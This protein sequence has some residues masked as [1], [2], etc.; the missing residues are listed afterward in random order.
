MNQKVDVKNELRLEAE[1]LNQMINMMTLF[2][3]KTV[4]EWLPDI[5]SQIGVSGEQLSIML[6]LNMAP[7][8]NLKNLA[9]NLM[10]APSNV[11]V[12]IQI[13]V[14]KGLV[15]RV[16]NPKD[17]RCVLLQLS[18]KG[19]KLFAL[20]EEHLVIKYQ[21]YLKTLSEKNQKN[22]AQA[23]LQMLKVIENILQPSRKDDEK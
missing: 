10:A 19:E 3:R 4:L 22:L 2:T 7:N 16:T 6:E 18:S 9:Q 15:S 21:E 11:S 17:R 14:E 5:S 13:M 12:A 20:A 1:T 23:N 8:Q